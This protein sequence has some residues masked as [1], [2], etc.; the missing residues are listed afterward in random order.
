MDRQSSA[1][2]MEMMLTKLVPL[3]VDVPVYL[4]GGWNRKLPT[5]GTAYGMPRYSDTSDA[6]GA[7]CPWTGPLLV[8]TVCPIVHCLLDR[9]EIHGELLDAATPTDGMTRTVLNT[10][11]HFILL[12]QVVSNKRNLDGTRWSPK[13]RLSDYA[14]SRMSKE[15]AT[16]P[17]RPRRRVPICADGVPAHLQQWNVMKHS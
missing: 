12:G 1:G 11:C 4:L 14:L 8:W 13:S 6:P 5:G 10:S 9:R 3:I 7:G 2:F 17:R 15:Y 16:L